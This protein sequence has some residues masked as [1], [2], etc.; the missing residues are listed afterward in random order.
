MYVIFNY[1]YFIWFF[2]LFQHSII[3]MVHNHFIQFIFLIYIIYYVIE[4]KKYVW[5][6]FFTL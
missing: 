4:V 2:L 3:L 1:F 5:F 6:F